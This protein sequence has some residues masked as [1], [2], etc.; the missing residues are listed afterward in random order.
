LPSRSGKYI[1]VCTF[2]SKTVDFTEEVS[3]GFKVFLRLL[4][5]PNVHEEINVFKNN[6]VMHSIMYL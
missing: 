2:P 5:N 6:K 1:S 4:G 3:I